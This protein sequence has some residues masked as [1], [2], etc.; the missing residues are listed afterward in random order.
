MVRE[1]I[2]RPIPVRAFRGGELLELSVVP[3][4]LQS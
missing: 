2:G 4:E 1:R 3:A